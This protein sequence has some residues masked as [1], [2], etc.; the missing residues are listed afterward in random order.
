MK[1]LVIGPLLSPAADRSRRD[2]DESKGADSDDADRDEIVGDMM[3]A[4]KSS[5]VRKFRAALDE[6]MEHR[7]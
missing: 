5:D 1:S 6:Y 7:K 4:A 3:R 2:G